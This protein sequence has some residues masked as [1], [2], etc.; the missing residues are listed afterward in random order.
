MKKTDICAVFGNALDNAMEA[1]EGLPAEK[2]RISLEARMGKG[3]LAVSIRNPGKL[4]ESRDGEEIK[5]EIPVTTK[6]DRSAHGFGL[7]SIRAALDRYSGTMELR[8]SGEE[9]CLFL[10][11]HLQK[12]KGS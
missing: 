9:V 3:L 12:E 4:S 5:R 10:Y 7:P 6:T 1:V 11:C 8:Q 2:R